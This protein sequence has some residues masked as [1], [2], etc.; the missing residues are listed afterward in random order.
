MFNF[1]QLKKKP[2]LLLALLPIISLILFLGFGYGIY[3]YSIEPLIILATIIAS[4]AATYLGYT[5]QEIMDSIVEKLGK[6]MPAILILIIVGFMIGSW[7]IGGT[8]PIMVYFGLKVIN[9]QF[10]IITS[11]LVSALVSLSTGTSWG[12]AGTIGVAL[13]GVAGSMDASPAM[14]A[15]AVISGAYFGDK[16]SPLSDSANLAAIAAGS[17][18]YENIGHMIYTT[19]PAFIIAGIVYF[20]IGINSAGA[21]QEIP[22]KVSL[23]LTSL[24]SYF[25]WNLMLF[26]PLLI[27]LIGSIA[28]KPT[29]PVMLISGFT[30]I[31]NSVLFE[32]FTI[33][34]ALQAS[35]TGFETSMLAIKG[36][37]SNQ[38]PDF[39]HALMNRGG[40]VSMLDTVL[41]ALFAFGFAGVL[42]VSGSLEILLN[43][44]LRFV[45]STGSLITSTIIACIAS[46]FITC[47]ANLAILIPGELFQDSYQKMGL[48]PKNLSR[49]LEDSAVLIDP[50]VPWTP[51]AIF[52]SA[53]LGVSTLQ[54]LPWAF[55]CYLCI[56][57]AILYGYT[58]FGIAHLEE[59]LQN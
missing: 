49:T 47:N 3:S 31:I 18:L 52:M 8:I 21:A 9:P 13:M 55:L 48:H 38:I 17:K 16:M 15:G 54:Y 46:I 25:T 42:S 32:K 1:R 39:L 33:G 35:V 51:A 26:V 59:K 24:D 41:I 57:F 37:E 2:H 30:A 36:I 53:T 4:L 14:V 20:I 5:W 56:P 50:L 12:T 27:I 23:I 40:M 34:Q 43:V 58:G 22:E 45:R 10:L 44:L 6:A 19:L 7:M 28:R 29:I 11:F